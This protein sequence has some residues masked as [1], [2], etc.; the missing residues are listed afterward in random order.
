MK[1]TVATNAQAATVSQQLL[2]AMTPYERA[3]LAWLTGVGPIPTWDWMLAY[4]K[5]LKPGRPA[6]WER[7]K[8]LPGLFQAEAQR[9]VIMKPGQ[10]GASEFAISRAF[11]LAE[12]FGATVLYTFP[13]STAI[14]DF[15]RSRFSAAVEASPHLS[16]IVVGGGGKKKGADNVGLKRVGN[17]YLYLRG[18]QPGPNGDYPQL[19]SVDADAVFYDEF[20]RQGD[21]V[22][23]YGEKRVGASLLQIFLW[24]STPT[25]D[26][27]GVDTKYDKS[28]QRR[29]FIRCGA[30]G[31]RQYL[32]IDHV[33]LE[34]DSLKR[35]TRWHG[36]AENRAYCAC[37]KC[38]KELNRLADGE[39]VTTYPS[40]SANLVGFHFSKLIVPTAM[41][42][43]SSAEFPDQGRGILNKLMKV[44]DKSRRQTFNQ[45]LAVPYAITGGR[46]TDR[47]LGNCKRNYGFPENYRKPAGK[48]VLM[49]VDVGVN[50]RH[51]IIRETP[52]GRGDRKLLYAGVVRHFRDVSKLIQRF[53]VDVCVVDAN[54]ERDEARAFQ[55]AHPK[56]V[57]LAF[58][59][60]MAQG[61]KRETYAV[62]TEDRHAESV[63]GGGTAWFGRVDIDRTWSLDV[64]LARF[65]SA[66]DRESTTYK[67]GNILPASIVNVPNYFKQLK[68]PQKVIEETRSG[69][70]VA[71]YVH[72]NSEP[73]DYA[74]AE[75]YCTVAELAPVRGGGWALGGG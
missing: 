16:N 65:Y 7:F 54:P 47:I 48:R 57:W 50:K 63:K 37:Q 68:A 34:W 11:Y 39:W 29:W 10:A 32:T 43:D 49:G 36:Q 38:G 14:G 20:D 1:S 33:V 44:D 69:V 58:Y 19:V 27:Y 73:D 24:V 41:L 4:R 6:D 23:A 53:D 3:E 45:D 18:G 40:R 28:D 46:L 13:T 17:G 62:F 21:E 42:W 25:Y 71:K 31:E 66:A 2:A 59:P 22:E 51:C 74:H 56:K 72:K 9:M 15:S 70:R 30:C 75:N 5:M 55:E 35:P 52:D 26:D 60:N 67:G 61:A 8:F 64:T 12:K